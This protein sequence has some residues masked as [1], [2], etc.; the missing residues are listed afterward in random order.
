VRPH[1]KGW[2][3]GARDFHDP[4]G[5]FIDRD[6]LLGCGTYLRADILGVTPSMH[7]ASGGTG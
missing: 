7:A 3:Q 4:E 6:K 5:A 2:E 1:D